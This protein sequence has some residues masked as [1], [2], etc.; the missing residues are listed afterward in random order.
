[1]RYVV[2]TFKYFCYYLALFFIVLIC[3]LLNY[4][5]FLN[6]SI[7]NIIE[8]IVLS[9]IVTIQ[10]VADNFISAGSKDSFIILLILFYCYILSRSNKVQK[11]ILLGSVLS[12]MIAM[13]IIPPIIPY[14]ETVSMNG[15]EQRWNRAANAYAYEINK[16]QNFKI[17]I[18]FLIGTISL[19]YLARKKKKPKKALPS[20]VLLFGLNPFG[21][22][23]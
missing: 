16:V 5:K 4:E 1:M 8:F 20:S 14:T 11:I 17:L 2:K 18:V 21:N 23:K 22:S 13:M 6:D 15:I 10:T 12:F 3:S 19:C 7:F 9:P